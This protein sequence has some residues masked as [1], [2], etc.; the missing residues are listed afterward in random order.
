MSNYANCD[1]L[2]I[3][4][5][6]LWKAAINDADSGYECKS[7]MIFYA[8]S[9]L[10]LLMENSNYRSAIL[11][12]SNYDANGELKYSDLF[13]SQTG[14]KDA[15]ESYIDLYSNCKGPHVTTYAQMLEYMYF[16]GHQYYPTIYFINLSNV[17][18]N[19][20]YFVAI[21]REYIADDLN[22]VSTFDTNK[23]PAW[24]IRTDDENV[25]EVLYNESQA[26]EAT[27]PILI[28][29]DGSDDVESPTASA[30]VID[31]VGNNLYKSWNSGWAVTSFRAQYRYD[32]SRHSEIWQTERSWNN[33]SITCS[34]SRQIGYIYKG[35][36]PCCNRPMSTNWPKVNTGGG[37]YHC[38]FEYDWYASM[39]GVAVA[40][41]SSSGGTKI[42]ECRMVNIDEWYQTFCWPWN[43]YTVINFDNSK[44]QEN[45]DLNK[46]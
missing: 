26:N 45:L 1:S 32:N 18:Y 25:E 21:G 39:Q 34:L 22:E 15:F 8:T 27:D 31:S 28:T 10:S 38:A 44:G 19:N 37:V 23:I 5:S 42:L 12:P 7:K 46:P 24:G 40:G 30:C 11:N 2:K 4:S 9:A 36:I 35:S 33:G 29:C 16:R 13:I 43:V 14:L 3:D 6:M 41:S 17:S 20:K